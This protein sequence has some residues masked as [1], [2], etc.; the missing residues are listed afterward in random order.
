MANEFQ[1]SR[2]F[3]EQS[4]T[5]WIYHVWS[6]NLPTKF[7]T[8]ESGDIKRTIQFRTSD[9]GYLRH[10][11]WTLRWRQPSPTTD[12]ECAH[13]TRCCT[14]YR[15]RRYIERMVTTSY[16]RNSRGSPYVHHLAVDSSDWSIRRY[17]GSTHNGATAPYTPMPVPTTPHDTR[18]RSVPTTESAFTA[19][20][21]CMN[22]I[23]T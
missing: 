7:S 5:G 23:P 22:R 11:S 2:Q 20:T 13:S 15:L 16:C 3:I 14:E 18:G 8:A 17:R 10:Y 9:G 21:C 4:T 12:A 19:T 1:E 6:R